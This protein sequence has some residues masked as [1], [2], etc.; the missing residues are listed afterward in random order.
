MRPPATSRRPPRSSLKACA[1]A[2]LKF[3]GIVPAIVEAARAAV[4]FRTTIE[5]MTKLD[6]DLMDKMGIKRERIKEVNNMLLYRAKSGH[7]EAKPMATEAPKYLNAA[8][9]VGIRGVEGR[10]FAGA[11]TQTMML[12][13][14]ATQPSKVSTF[15]EHGLRHI[16]ARQ[17]VKG[18]K[19]FGID[20]K[21]YMPKGKFYGTGGVEC[22]LDLAASMK[23]KGLDDPFKV[24][25]AGFREMY[26][27]KFWKQVMQY[28][29]V[30]RLAMAEFATA[31]A[32][33]MAGGDKAEIERSNFGKIKKAIIA[34]LPLNRFSRC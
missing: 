22:I 27:K 8:A 4:A 2:G 11:M 1:A 28:N 16:T 15:M 26:I 32:N 12:L 21:K 9:S 3:D 23:S 5:D 31:A 33:D 30:I 10:N 6:F 14:P 13:A 17:Q 24:D 34:S 7:F 29:G 20:V 18:L 19:K 25:E